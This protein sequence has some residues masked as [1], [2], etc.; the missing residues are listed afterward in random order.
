MAPHNEAIVRRSWGLLEG[1]AERYG[2]NFQYSELFATGGLIS[3]AMTSLAI[4]A[5]GAALMFISPLRHLV[6]RYG[7]QPG[8]GPS[9]ED[10]KNG[11]RLSF[12]CL[13]QS[14]DQS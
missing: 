6:S 2:P 9:L 4:Y 8:E 11:T 13:A 5:I 14:I 3:A 10:Q 12:L 7:P 1:T